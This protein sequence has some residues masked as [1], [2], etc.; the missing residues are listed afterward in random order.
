MATRKTSRADKPVVRPRP[1]D[2][3]TRRYSAIVGGVL[4][5]AGVAWFAWLAVHQF[6]G[7]AISMRFPFIGQSQPTVQPTV[8]PLIAAGITLA[9]PSQNQVAQLSQAQALLLADQTEPQ[10]AAHAS[11]V[12]ATYVLFSYKENH[13]VPAWL[14]HY[15]KVNEPGP[16]TTADPHATSTAHDCYVFLNATSGQELLALWT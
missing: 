9:T 3:A 11:S 13:A 1:S 14:V 4:I 12:N 15:S 16:D 7:S 10:A 5:C 8:D 2:S 6:N